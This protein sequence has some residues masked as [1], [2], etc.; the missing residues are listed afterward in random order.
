[1]FRLNFILMGPRNLYQTETD[2]E[3]TDSL[4]GGCVR[5]GNRGIVPFV[6]IHNLV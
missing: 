2:P 3:F 4:N 1:M 5:Y 6:S